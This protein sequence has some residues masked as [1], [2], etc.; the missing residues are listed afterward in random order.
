MI[1]YENLPRFCPQCR[2][3]GHTKESCKVKKP[4]SKVVP[5]NPV[6]TDIEKG[7]GSDVTKAE[8]QITTSGTGEGKKHQQEWIIK[9]TRA[10]KGK[11]GSTERGRQ[12]D[13]QSAR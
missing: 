11:S 7:K 13:I 5:E 4:P 3:V 9:Q 10:P 8:G 2:V 1:N 12:R 6:E